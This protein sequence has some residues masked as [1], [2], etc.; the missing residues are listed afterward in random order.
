MRTTAME[1]AQGSYSHEEEFRGLHV[2]MGNV[3]TKSNGRRDKH[4]PITMKSLQRQVQSYR[5]DNEKIM[6]TQ[7]E[8]LQSLNMSQKK[9]NKD[10]GT[11]QEASARQVTASKSHSRRNEHGND[12]KSRS[13]DHH[14]PKQSRKSRSRSRGHHSPEQSTRRAHVSSRPG[15]IPSVSLV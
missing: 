15:S 2:S 12:R 13:R 14:S 1:D 7:K 11:K 6:K 5:V 10:Y 3:G 9:A 8:I 4:E